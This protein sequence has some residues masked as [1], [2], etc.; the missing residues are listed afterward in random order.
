MTGWK[1]AVGL[2]ERSCAAAAALIMEC[3]EATRVEAGGYLAV[4]RAGFSRMVTEKI[5]ANP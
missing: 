1:N 4:D 5:K 3:A 2:L